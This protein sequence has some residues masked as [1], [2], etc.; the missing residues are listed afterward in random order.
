MAAP[1]PSSRLARRRAK[2]RPGPGR[3]RPRDRA[4]GARD[5]AY[6][7]RWIA[8]ELAVLKRAIAHVP[9]FGACFGAQLLASALSGRVAPLVDTR[10]VIEIT[11]FPCPDRVLRLADAAELLAAVV[12]ADGVR[13]PSSSPTWAAWTGALDPGAAT[14][15]ASPARPSRSRRPTWAGPSQP[16]SRCSP[17]SSSA[18]PRRAC[19]SGRMCRRASVTR[20]RPRPRGAGRGRRTS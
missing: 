10:C 6:D 19:G 2:A 5:S 11:S 18:R 12:R 16:R 17:R 20:G 14:I 4:G 15:A 8:D 1:G 3:L 7:H 13:Y 9:V